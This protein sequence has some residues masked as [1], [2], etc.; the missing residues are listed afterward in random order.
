M[1]YV[2]IVRILN[3]NNNNKPT[4]EGTREKI[5]KETNQVKS[6]ILE[7]AK[8]TGLLSCHTP[9]IPLCWRW[10]RRTVRNSRSSL[11]TEQVLG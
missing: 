6:Y 5:T 7:T 9:L 1:S 10:G 11:A 4:K 2:S 3:K 8:A